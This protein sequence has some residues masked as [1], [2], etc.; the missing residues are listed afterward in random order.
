MPDFAQKTLPS[1]DVTSREGKVLDAAD[2][3][4]KIA[5]E[6]KNIYDTHGHTVGQIED[7]GMTG[8][9]ESLQWKGTRI[10]ETIFPD[11]NMIFATW[12]KPKQIR[13]CRT[14]RV[15]MS[16]AGVWHFNQ[17][18]VFQ[19]IE[20]LEKG[21]AQRS[22]P[23]L[24]M[25]MGD[26]KTAV[27]FLR[28]IVQENRN[29]DVTDP[30]Y[31]RIK[32]A[33]LIE[34]R[35]SYWI[36]VL[37][38]HEEGNGKFKSCEDAFDNINGKD[39]QKR[40]K[41]VEDQINALVG[42]KVIFI[43][44]RNR[45]ESLCFE[46]VPIEKPEIT[47]EFDV[48][49]PVQRRVSGLHYPPPM[50]EEDGK[51]TITEYKGELVRKVK[52]EE[53][54]VFTAE[55]AKHVIEVITSEMLESDEEKKKPVTMSMPPMFE[56]HLDGKK[57]DSL[58]A[59]VDGSRLSIKVTK[60]DAWPEKAREFTPT[61][62]YLFATPYSDAISAG[63]LEKNIDELE[64]KKVDLGDLPHLKAS[65]TTELS[66]GLEK[67]MVYD[68]FLRGKNE[69][70]DVILI[71]GGRLTTKGLTES[72]PTPITFE[73]MKFMALTDLG[74][75]PKEAKGIEAEVKP[76]T[77]WGSGGRF[78]IAGFEFGRKGS[79]DVGVMVQ[80]NGGVDHNHGYSTEEIRGFI[81]SGSRSQRPK[82]GILR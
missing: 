18:G 45:L 26:L 69:K 60:K 7:A 81:R 31:D 67:D 49:K 6:L 4:E 78:I 54:A 44:I 35:P 42:K 25:H 11:A 52:A 2:K 5:D 51:I 56:I 82:T 76:L 3:L 50:R 21:E 75:T 40:I 24:P 61:G 22:F 17:G 28:A 63:A 1:P 20:Q 64:G 14:M 30:Y 12:P 70:G 58:F 19:F 48:R 57:L 38:N 16:K 53:Y 29:P 74:Y 71:A 10:Y 37:I 41:K 77:A 32:D 68:I 23:D 8:R 66:A 34:P 9:T 27:N 15:E 73:E 72:V 62:L 55:A 33:Y 43:P 65:A 13:G 46:H 79:N 59:V 36:P 47:F 39:T 80:H